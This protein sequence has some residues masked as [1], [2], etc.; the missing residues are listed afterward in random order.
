M[1]THAIPELTRSCDDLANSVTLGEVA[2]LMHV[3]L[4]VQA[5]L[6][7]VRVGLQSMA[8]RDVLYRSG[9][10]FESF[11]VVLSG[12]LKLAAVGDAGREQVFAFVL[13]GETAGV[14]GFQGGS[15][16]VD[17]TALDAVEVALVPFA[18][19]EQLAALAGE[20]ELGEQLVHRILTQAMVQDAGMLC[21]LETLDARTRVAAFLL[22]LGKRFQRVYTAPA[23]VDLPM[24]DA[25][26]GSY[27]RLPPGA[28]G[29]VLCEFVEA[30]LFDVC[31]RAVS[32]ASRAGLEAL[33]EQGRQARISD[34]AAPTETPR[35]PPS[36]PHPT[37]RRRGRKA[38]REEATD[39]AARDAGRL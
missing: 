15:H 7:A 36:T 32:L 31:E 23:P 39:S 25:E 37:Q 2:G 3:P 4:P 35:P 5:R 29:S 20:R 12:L 21:L 30:G 33:V 9:D 8:P 13:S 18:K 19:L 24:T 11:Y 17:A 6:A 16:C 27:L 1:L 22:S 10:P 26:I 38:R 14:D 28:V 34:I